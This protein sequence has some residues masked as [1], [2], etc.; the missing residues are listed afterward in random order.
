M[1]PNGQSAIDRAIRSAGTQAELARRLDL[2]AQQV[3]F[4]TERGWASPK[5]ALKI[6]QATGVPCAELIADV[7]KKRKRLK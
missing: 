1:K 4:W 7:G 6:E 5:Y 3:W 2:A